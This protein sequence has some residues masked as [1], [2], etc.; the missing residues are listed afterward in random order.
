[1]SEQPFPPRLV[2]SNGKSVLPNHLVDFRGSGLT[3]EMIRAAG[4]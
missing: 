1:M 2:L 3:D 4:V